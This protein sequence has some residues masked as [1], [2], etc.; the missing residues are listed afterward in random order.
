M[1]DYEYP[2]S[3]TQVEKGSEWTVNI[4]GKWYPSKVRI[5]YPDG[6][7]V[8][9]HVE[10]GKF[11]FEQVLELER[12]RRVREPDYEVWLQRFEELRRAGREAWKER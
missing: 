6:R 2:T 10:D 4:A 11:R 5:V 1:E 12:L 9:V 7:G 8:G 3:W